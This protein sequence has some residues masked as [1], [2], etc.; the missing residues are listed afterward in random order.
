MPDT[1][2]IRYL[3]HRG[4]LLLCVAESLTGTRSTAG[5]SAP[6]RP[7]RTQDFSA[8]IVT[9]DPSGTVIGADAKLYVSSG[10][11]RIETADA[12][13][14]FFLVDGESGVPLFVLTGRRVFMD[15]GR[16]TRLTQIFI[17]VNPGDPCE[18]WQAAA[19]HAGVPL[20]QGAWHCQRTGNTS[21][22]GRAV[23]ELH[24]VSPGLESS[25]RWI[26]P[27]LGFAVK[28]QWTDGT[29][30][31]LE[32]IR[33]QA[34]PAGLFAVPADYQKLDPQSL[35]ERIKHSDVWAGGSTD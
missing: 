10:K 7:P 25:Q 22:D 6:A 23:F 15:A 31:A 20:A 17:P 1:S 13:G 32:H 28:L 34:Q 21:I 12:A 8:D 27:E 35:I 19:S 4:F 5:T 14:G 9:R 29:T 2:C 11:V 3:V 30:V 26:D 16:S 18:Q 24:V 33:T